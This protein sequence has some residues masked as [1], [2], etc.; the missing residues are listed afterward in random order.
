[1]TYIFSVRVRGD[2]PARERREETQLPAD[3]QMYKR[4]RKLQFRPRPGMITARDPDFGEGGM[5]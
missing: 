5:Q 4:Q 3:V 2:E 1:M